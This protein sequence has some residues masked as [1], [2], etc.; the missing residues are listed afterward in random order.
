MQKFV[1]S[2]IVVFEDKMLDRETERGLQNNHDDEGG[3]VFSGEA[4]QGR[5][6]GIRRG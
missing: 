4:G 5:C 1:L 2:G 6:S 3:H